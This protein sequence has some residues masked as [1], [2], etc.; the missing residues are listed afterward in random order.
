MLAIRV[1]NRCASS[2]AFD[3][4][5]LV[6]INRRIKRT[7]PLLEKSLGSSKQKAVTWELSENGRGPAE[8]RKVPLTD[9]QTV[10]S[11]NQSAN[12]RGQADSCN[13]CRN[14]QR[15]VHR[16]AK[17]ATLFAAWRLR[18]IRQLLHM[19][20]MVRQPVAVDVNHLRRTCKAHQQ[21]TGARQHSQPER[22]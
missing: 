12:H 19:R 2:R 20:R 16:H 11:G 6:K 4:G 17:R 9:R 3:R 18:S 22:M 13:P 21:Q 14:R 10:D 7:V 15:R 5:S 8:P 1:P